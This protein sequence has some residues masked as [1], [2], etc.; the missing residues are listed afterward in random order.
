[1]SK[2]VSARET[3]RDWTVLNDSFVLL[4]PTLVALVI[5]SAE[6]FSFSFAFNSRLLNNGIKLVQI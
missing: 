1:M 6:S 4:L 5:G 3:E 2:I